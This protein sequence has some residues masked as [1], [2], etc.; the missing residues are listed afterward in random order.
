[1][2]TV[3]AWNQL[4]TIKDAFDSATLDP[5]I[6]DGRAATSLGIRIQAVNDFTVGK[7]TTNILLFPGLNAGLAVQD[8]APETTGGASRAY[9]MAL[10]GGVKFDMT[11]TDDGWTY[12]Q[13]ANQDASRW[14]CVSQ[15]V[16]LTLINNSEDDDGWFEAIRF[17]PQADEAQLIGTNKGLVPDQ[18]LFKKNQEAAG[19]NLIQHNNYMTGKLRDIHKY[20]FYLQHHQPE[21][22]FINLKD[23]YSLTENKSA[24]EDAR[25][26]LWDHSMDCVL[27]RIHG[28]K[29]PDNATSCCR[30]TKIMAH[31]VSNHEYMYSESSPMVRLQTRGTDAGQILDRTIQQQN[32]ATGAGQVVGMVTPQNSPQ[33]RKKPG[34]PPSKKQKKGN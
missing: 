3:Q 14:R 25:D 23:Q 9:H 17:V 2:P 22:D 28:R 4:K 5:K 19:A 15:A 12:T 8:V 7:D 32:A 33:K 1:M 29:T 10:D 21:H 20:Q 18:T 30:G 24:W 16:K 13:D 27:I 26:Q 34:K 11:Q 6:P 31:L